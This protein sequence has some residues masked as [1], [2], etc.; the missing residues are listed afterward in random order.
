M[1]INRLNVYAGLFEVLSL[2]R[3]ATEDHL[4]LPK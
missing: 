3:D 4:S 1:G 2:M